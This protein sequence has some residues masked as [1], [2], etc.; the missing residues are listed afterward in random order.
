MEYPRQNNNVAIRLTKFAI[1][2]VSIW[3]ASR[4]IA[5]SGALIL[6]DKCDGQTI[7]AAESWVD[8][9]RLLLALIYGYWLTRY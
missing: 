7:S 4:V 1:V 8:T 6:A 2:L 5:L 9:T 3:Y